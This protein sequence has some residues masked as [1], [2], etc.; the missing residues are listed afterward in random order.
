M[1]K[2]LLLVLGVMLVGSMAFGQATQVLSRNAVGYV[3]ID[4]RSNG[5]TL[6]SIP[7]NA[8]SNTISGVLGSQL[9]GNN[10]PA[11]AD[12]IFKW[13]NAV[14]TYVR[15]YKR[16]TPENEWRKVGETV[17]TT[18]TL[19]PGESFFIKNSRLTNQTVYLM[20]EVPDALTAPTS[21]VS[22]VPGLQMISYSYPV[23][24]AI[25][26]LTLFDTAIKN[27][28]PAGADQILKWDIPAQTYIR[29]YVRTTGWRKVGETTN[30]ADTLTPNEGFFYLRRGTTSFDWTEKKPYTWP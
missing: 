26:N 15:Y 12:Q 1:K 8:F 17:P 18:D 30:T 27:N 29:Y 23:E 5:L 22:G 14:Q 9:V 7:F 3:K 4:A 13:D 20:G 2:I 6:V 16:A 21:T 10:N 11:G 24:T 25:S 28:N 19:S